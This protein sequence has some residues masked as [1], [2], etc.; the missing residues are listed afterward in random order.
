MAGVLTTV[1]LARYL[2][3]TGYGKYILV[4]AYTSFIVEACGLSIETVLVR[5]FAKGLDRLSNRALWHGVLI[6][7][8]GGIL[9]SL[10]LLAIIYLSSKDV[11]L[12]ISALPV[13]ISI[14][15]TSLFLAYASVIRAS[16]RIEWE[17]CIDLIA[18]IA[19]LGL[20]ALGIMVV[21]T[22]SFFLLA[23]TISFLLAETLRLILMMVVT[24]S[25]L[26]PT[27][28]RNKATMRHLLKQSLPLGLANT[29][30]S[31]YRRVDKFMLS[32][33]IGFGAV[34]IYG[35]SY[36][37]IE[38]V[39]IVSGIIMVSLFPMLSKDSSRGAEKLLRTYRKSLTYN[40]M[41]GLAITL[42][43]IAGGRFFI[44]AIF[45]NSYEDA[46]PLLYI[47]SLLAP[48]ILSSNVLGH[49]MVILELQG[50]PYIIIRSGSLLVEIGLIA[51]FV[52][53]LNMPG[54]AVALVITEFLACISLLLFVEIHLRRMRFCISGCY[55]NRDN[56]VGTK[57]AQQ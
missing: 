29:I 57:S 41:I 44:R 25:F 40:A 8:S 43:L 2:G 54:V 33:L 7:L 48:L 55:S 56:A 34:G 6:K 47:L 26:I 46:V 52:P 36:K 10:L 49:M 35:A 13:A 19:F 50:K 23:V 18:K 45:G 9:G 14:P 21:A 12:L 39:W 11:N 28:Q 32:Y 31:F 15:I 3:A 27:R 4:F 37:F 20:S 30:G 24:R 38:T 17:V 5:D 42:G 1:L 22:S 51:C 16:L 53:V